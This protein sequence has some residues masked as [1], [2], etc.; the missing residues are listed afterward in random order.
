MRLLKRVL[1]VAGVFV[2]LLLAAI[3]VRAMYAF[4]DRNPGHSVSISIEGGTS[5]AGTGSLQA[6]FGRR[7]INPDLSDPS[8]QCGS[9][10]S[11]RGAPQRAS[12]TTS[13]PLPAWWTTAGLASPSWVSTPSGCSTT[14]SLPSADSSRRTG[15]S[16]TPS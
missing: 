7:K 11:T 10:D 4:R 1:V 16:P 13:G 9:R 6:G 2:T 3:A 8:R 14:T 15:G 12:T 5:A